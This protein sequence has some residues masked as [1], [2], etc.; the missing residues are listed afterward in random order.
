MHP[1][2]DDAELLGL[3]TTHTEVELLFR[4][5]S[6]HVTVTFPVTPAS[7]HALLH[8]TAL[9]G[10]APGCTAA[11]AV[12][13]DLL[14]RCLEATQRPATSVVVRPGPHPGCWLR[15]SGPH[16]VELD[17]NIL[18]AFCLLASRRIPIQLRRDDQPPTGAA[19]TTDWDSVLRQLL[20][21]QE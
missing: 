15:L 8:L 16:P 13:V 10:H 20:H 14:L 21:Q 7:R 18:D 11:P 4:S 19:P 17:L 6:E 1:A 5:G 12:Y 9:H 2:S 3:N